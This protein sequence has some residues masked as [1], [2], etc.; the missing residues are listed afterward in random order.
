MVF[1]PLIIVKGP[2]L[3]PLNGVLVEEPVTILE[4]E[5]LVIGIDTCLK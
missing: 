5:E 2:P 4:E 1:V 3:S